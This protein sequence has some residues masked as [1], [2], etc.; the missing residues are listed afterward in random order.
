MVHIVQVSTFNNRSRFSLQPDILGRATGDGID[1]LLISESPR[2]RDLQFAS[3]RSAHSV[4]RLDGVDGAGR[5]YEV[6]VIYGDRAAIAIIN[7]AIELLEHSVSVGCRY[8]NATVTLPDGR[9]LEIRSIYAPVD[10]VERADFFRSDG[11]N[12]RSISH[13]ASVV[14]GGDFNDYPGENDR[15]TFDSNAEQLPNRRWDLLSDMITALGLVD[16][17]RYKW[18]EREFFTRFHHAP[19]PSDDN[20]RGLISATRLDIILVSGPGPLH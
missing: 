14:V 15:Y 10:L 7:P 5:P 20:P 8:A 11:L 19:R 18:P 9:A 2:L 3:R 16:A 17:L 13:G 12:L 6:T 1:I 4:S